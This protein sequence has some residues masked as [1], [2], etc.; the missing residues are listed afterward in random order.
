MDNKNL[1][2]LIKESFSKVNRRFSVRQEQATHSVQH[3][4]INDRL[5]SIEST[6]TVAH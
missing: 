2:K 1:A 3:T 6:P 4:D 5:E